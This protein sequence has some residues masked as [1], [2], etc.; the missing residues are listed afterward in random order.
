[1]Q[2]GLDFPPLQIIFLIIFVNSR[3]HIQRKTRNAAL[4]RGAGRYTH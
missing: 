2:V 4:V 3:L 1:M